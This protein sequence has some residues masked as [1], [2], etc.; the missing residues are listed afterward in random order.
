MAKCPGADRLRDMKI[1]GK[2]CPECGREIE[3]YSIL[4]TAECECGFTAYNE[5]Q[6]CL[7]W[8]AY[9]RECVGEELYNKYYAEKGERRKS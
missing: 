9:A 7:Q 2:P 5:T 8:C 4:P 6:S 3:V 1:V